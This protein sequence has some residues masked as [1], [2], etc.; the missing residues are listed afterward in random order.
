MKLPA[1]HPLRLRII[2]NATTTPSR[3]FT[4]TSPKLNTNNNPPQNDTKTNRPFNLDAYLQTATKTLASH[5]PKLLHDTL[6]PTPSHLLTLALVDH[7]PPTPSFTSPSPQGPG[8]FTCYPPPPPT[9]PL[10]QGHHLVYFP[11]QVPPS[12]LLPDGTDPDHGPGWPFVRRMWA[13]GSVAFAR[14]W[15]AALRLDGRRAVC[16]ETVGVP[17]GRG[18][19]VFVEVRRRYGVGEGVVEGRGV[20]VDEL[21]RLV[22]MREKGGGRRGEG[23]KVRGMFFLVSSPAAPSFSFTLRPD[24]TLLFHFSALSYNAH[25]IHLNPEY[26]R[27][28]EGYRGLLVHGPLT[29]VLMLSALRF[30]QTQDPKL[31]TWVESIDY[32]NLAPLYVDEELKVCLREMGQGT[33]A[34]PRERRWQVWIEGPDGELAVKGTATTVTTTTRD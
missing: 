25:A 34:T 4:S 32:R 15:D 21:R 30:S 20:V 31:Q 16:V 27:V 9:T 22:F 33:I 14:G 24:A 26:A 17:V 11:I 5:P 18:D 3:Q 29:L 13:G 7:L 6:S 19:K 12:R 10:P 8:S 2:K 28:Q 23:R 1:S